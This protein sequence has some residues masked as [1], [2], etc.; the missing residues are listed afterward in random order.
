[1]R[2]SLLILTCALAG[3]G[4]IVEAGP[5]ALATD[6]GSETSTSEPSAVAR[7]SE[8]SFETTPPGAVDSGDCSLAGT[9]DSQAGVGGPWE[10][11]AGTF[12]FDGKG[13]FIGGAL[14][15][16][17]CGAPTI[18]GTYRL[19][20]RSF[21]ILTSTGMGCSYA[22]GWA[23]AF[24]GDCK[25]AKLTMK[26]DNCTGARHSIEYDTWLTKK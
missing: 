16:D 15:A 14:G 26:Y 5:S 6:G 23:I 18:T 11:T 2:S 1:M 3:C 12:A 22:A 4:G 19:A 9:W 8:C 10:K 13:H 20:G 17:V 25:S 21:E 7:P 24:S